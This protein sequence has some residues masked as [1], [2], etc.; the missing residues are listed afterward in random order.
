MPVELQIDAR[1]MSRL[2]RAVGRIKDGVPKALVPAINR[3]LDKGRTEVR[4]EIR[5]EY[6]I[7]QKD[8]PI[9]MKRA[10]RSRLAGEVRVE[11]GMLNLS[12]FKVVPRGV[13][14][15]KVKRFL[16]VQV[17]KGGGGTLRHAFFIPSGGPY[18]RIG[19]SRHPIFM[20]KTI[21]AAIMASQPSVGPAASQGMSDT[22]A[23][24][25]DH[26]IERVMVNAGG[27]T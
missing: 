4:R 7:K 24:R 25:I 16:R 10:T 23:K 21:G 13:Q 3:A 1:Q 11:Q 27:H 2:F 6:L 12:K 17:K 15:R 26:E 22:L 20:L 5:K 18:S 9:A 14:K 8:I 19:P